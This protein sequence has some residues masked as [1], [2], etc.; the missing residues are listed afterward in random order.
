MTDN[1]LYK[2]LAKAEAMAELQ[3]SELTETLQAAYER[4]CAD[5]NAQDAAA[6][7]RKLRDRLL[8]E[9]D[10]KMSIDRLGLTA[11]SGSTFT[12]WLL[13]L[14]KLGDVLTGSWANYRKALRDLPE[15][16]GFPFN[17]TFPE[18]PDSGNAPE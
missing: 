2:R 16:E 18:R 10:N 6:Y 1:T 9:S 17:I 4:A 15:Q 7:A 11:P 5:E 12:A 14:R 3:K 13:F 8:A